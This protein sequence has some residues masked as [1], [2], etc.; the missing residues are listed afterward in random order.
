[1]AKS[2]SKRSKKSMKH[3]S[4]ASMPAGDL[5]RPVEQNAAA[6]S[7]IGPTHAGRGMSVPQSG[8]PGEG[9]QATSMPG[10]MGVIQDVM[11]GSGRAH[12]IPG[13]VNTTS[14]GPEV[15]QR[16]VS[17]IIV[18]AMGGHMQE[19]EQGPVQKVAGHDATA[20]NAGMRHI[21]GTK[22]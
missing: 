16:L 9:Q 21:P 22:Y 8:R 17:G 2:D 7:K 12:G 19:K 13:I 3:D 1:M 20:Y 15:R 11:K 5:P 4:G 18:S 14:L 6:V 10:H